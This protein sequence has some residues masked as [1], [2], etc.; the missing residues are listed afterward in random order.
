MARKSRSPFDTWLE[1]QL[2]ATF[3]ALADEPLPPDLLRLIE[4]TQAHSQS[5]S[6]AAQRLARAEELLARQQLMVDRLA[7][8]GSDTRLAS[9]LLTTMTESVRQMLSHLELRMR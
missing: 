4:D 3:G 9:A 6:S 2:H 5:A 7:E 1:R 8:R